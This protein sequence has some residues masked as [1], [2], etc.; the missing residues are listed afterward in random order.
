MDE[1]LLVGEGGSGSGVSEDHDNALAAVLLGLARSGWL[2]GWLAVPVAAF[3][4]GTC[5]WDG[6]HV[7]YLLLLLLQLLGHTLRIQPQVIVP[8]A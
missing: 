2:A 1:P 3:W 4:A 7:A 6:G 8:S 5:R